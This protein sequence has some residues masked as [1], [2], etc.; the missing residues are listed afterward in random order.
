MKNILII[1]ALIL[2]NSQ[3]ILSQQNIWE[4]VGDP[5]EG[6]T[7]TVLSIDQDNNIFAGTYFDFYKSTNDGEEWVSVY[8]G[9]YVTSIVFNTQGEMFIGT[10]A[11]GGIFKSVNKGESWIQLN[12]SLIS[13]SISDLD[14]NSS[15]NLFAAIRGRGM[16]RSTD[17]GENW[18]EINNGLINYQSV[19]ELYIPKLGPIKDYLFVTVSE[20]SDFNYI[21]RSSDNGES[22]EQMNFYDSWL[23]PVTFI[24]TSDDVIYIG[25]VDSAPHSNG[26]AIF[27]SENFGYNWIS[28]GSGARTTALILDM[29]EFIY[30]GTFAGWLGGCQGIIRTTNGG[31]N[32][33]SFNSGLISSCGFVI[34]CNSE[35]IL[36]AGTETGIYKTIESTTDINEND[37]SIPQEFNLFQ[38]YPNPF[39]PSTKIKYSMSSNLK[40][41]TS[42]VSLK[43]Y[44]VLGNEVVILVNEDKPAG[45]YEI[46]FNVGSLS[47]GI[48]Y[49][50]LVA[51]SFSDTKKMILLK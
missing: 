29:N 46:E 30:A 13:F 27:K 20:P 1:I 6:N 17:N 25:L 24:S 31:N 15:D 40:R 10:G 26:G 41:E 21:F 28:A 9:Y 3:T 37:I 34:D 19:N 11:G 45:N 44:D 50:Q 33:E 4:P 35:G 32:W 18:E 38:N 48:Y 7:F 47:S 8:N 16:Y 23:W 14:I 22:W 39:N 5:L 12:D 2:S 49:Y 43:I 36:F 42:N 51:G